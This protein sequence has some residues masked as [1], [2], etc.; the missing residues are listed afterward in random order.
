MSLLP[1]DRPGELDDP[2]PAM[3]RLHEA[4]ESDGRLTKDALANTA[5][6]LHIPLV[7]L[8]DAATF[9]HYFGVGDDAEPISNAACAGP[10]CSLR[11]NQQWD[12]EGA[13]HAEIACPGLCDQPIP[14]FDGARF[15]A[16]GE[17]GFT[18]PRV[19]D[20]EEAL[21]RHIRDDRDGSIDSYRASGG[22]RQ[23]SRLANGETS[24]ESAME[25]LAS[26]GLT[27]RGGAAFCR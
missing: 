17:G 20:T 12:G 1:A 25:S 11:E 27:G 16:V 13:D 9:Y 3:S 5:T 14:T 24:V 22:Y 21:F 23:L 2:A 4:M 18:I 19:V 26:S 15:S 6:S 8:Y 10:T 7:D